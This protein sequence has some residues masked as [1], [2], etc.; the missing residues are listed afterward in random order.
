MTSEIKT[1]DRETTSPLLK[2]R[3]IDLNNTSDRDL[4]VK[5]LQEVQ[6]ANRKSIT[7]EDSF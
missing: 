2:N 3:N 7:T 4:L 6:N 5:K 1:K